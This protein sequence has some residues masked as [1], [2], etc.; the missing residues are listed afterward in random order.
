M[1]IKEIQIG[2]QILQ[3]V[4]AREEGVTPEEIVEFLG[5]EMSLN[6]LPINAEGIKKVHLLKDTDRANGRTLS[7][8][9]PDDGYFSKNNEGEIVT[10]TKVQVDA[11]EEELDGK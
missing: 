9:V 1:T 5:G 10:F 6:Y 7:M 4:K 2:G 8:W 3:L 11:I